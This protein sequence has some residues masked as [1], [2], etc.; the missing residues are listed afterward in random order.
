VICEAFVGPSESALLR[1]PAKSGTLK[2]E[3]RE[4]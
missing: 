3:P 4:A 2:S 1:P